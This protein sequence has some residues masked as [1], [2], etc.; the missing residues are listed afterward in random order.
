M[1]SIKYLL[2]LIIPLQEILKRFLYIE[3]YLLQSIKRLLQRI[4]H[5]QEMLK[6]F[7]YMEEYLLQTLEFWQ[8]VFEFEQ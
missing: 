3:E 8:L 7:L 6:R 1:Q 2:Q 4:I 5:F